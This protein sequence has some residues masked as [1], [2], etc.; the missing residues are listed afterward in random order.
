MCMEI[1]AR[2]FI[3]IVNGQP[4]PEKDGAG[5]MVGAEATLPRPQSDKRDPKNG[6]QKIWFQPAWPW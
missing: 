4:R 1:A 2:G 6:L 3:P 5:R